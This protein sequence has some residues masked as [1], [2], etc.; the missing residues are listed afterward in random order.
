MKQAADQP[1]VCSVCKWCNTGL[2]NVGEPGAAVWICQGCA[3]R[4]RDAARHA[5]KA[6]SDCGA[7]FSAL[8]GLL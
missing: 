2:W 4:L 8:R 5:C 6:W 3:K 1:N 7:A